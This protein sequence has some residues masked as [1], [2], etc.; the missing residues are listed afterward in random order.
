[1]YDGL[2]ARVVQGGDAAGETNFED[3]LMLKCGWM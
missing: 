3:L 1:M 2:Y